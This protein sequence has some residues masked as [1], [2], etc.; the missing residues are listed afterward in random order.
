MSEL[1]MNALASTTNVAYT[2]NGAKAFAT[3]TSGVLDLF[4]QGGALRNREA[5]DALRMFSTAYA[6]DAL[7]ATRAMF[8]FRDVR[9]GQG[10]RD[11]FRKQL[12][13]MATA[14]P[15]VVR[16][17]MH[18]ISTYGRWD[19]LYTLFDTELEKDAIALFKSQLTEDARSDHPSL[20]A[21]WLKSENT[22]SKESKRLGRKTRTG[23]G[24]SPKEYRLILS[25]LRKTIGVIEQLTSS[26][27]W[28][29]INYQSV[30]SQANLKYATA[31]YKHDAERRKMFLESV[32]K[33]EATINA[34]VLYPYE[35]VRKAQVVI[36]GQKHERDLVDTLWN[37]L[38]NY[39]G[40]N[41]ENAIAVVDVSGSMHGLPMDVAMSIGLYLSERNTCEA[42][43]NKFITF[44]AEPQLVNVVGDTLCEKVEN[45]K[46]AQWD[47]NTDIQ[48]VFRLILDVASK[49]GLTQDQIP[50]KLYI[51]SDMEFDAATT[52][53]GQYW[54]ADQATAGDVD[55]TLFQTIAQDYVTA[56]YTLPNLVFWN[57]NAR[58][59]QFPMSMDERGFQM[60]SGCSPSIFAST[61]KGEFVS[62]YDMML[63]VLNGERYQAV[64]V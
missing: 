61:M 43:H 33:G 16:K 46:R 36:H 3:T 55:K 52:T 51:I 20:L 12:K 37:A 27:K 1:F 32:K 18:L 56:G 50:H 44:S 7:L 57:V 19:D 62:A 59:A 8:Y 64:V 28:D 40:E 29:Q 15:D 47:M 2:E 60:V 49:N 6:E 10:E 5:T 23:L 39:I 26:N 21:K 48:A 63:E 41:Q 45:M 25:S 24:M 31:F 58:N 38:P 30:P 9:G 17:N 13:W 54:P 4:A 14:H 11:T 42:Y 22:S 53:G 34:S 35:L